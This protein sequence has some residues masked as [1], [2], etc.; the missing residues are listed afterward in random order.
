[1]ADEISIMF[2]R[3]R[4]SGQVINLVGPTITLPLTTLRYC[5]QPT[6]LPQY[7]GVWRN[8]GRTAISHTPARGMRLLLGNFVRECCASPSRR[9]EPNRRDLCFLRL[10]F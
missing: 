10:T 5:F 8:F 9:S 6:I 4:L 7:E 2:P 1:M 3:E